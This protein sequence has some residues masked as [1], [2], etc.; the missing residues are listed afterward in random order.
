[1]F[2]LTDSPNWVVFQPNIVIDAKLGCLWH[3]KLCLLEMCQQIKDLS[4]C[5]QVALRRAEG[6]SVLLNVGDSDRI[7]TYRVTFE[8]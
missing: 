1:M 6:K 4:V 3:I 7:V 2:E 8:F 5:T